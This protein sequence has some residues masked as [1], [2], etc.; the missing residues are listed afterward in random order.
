MNVDSGFIHNS[1]K[2]KTAVMSIKKGMDKQVVVFPY[3][4]FTR[5]GYKEIGG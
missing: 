3:N 4:E 2:L 1:Q 5:M